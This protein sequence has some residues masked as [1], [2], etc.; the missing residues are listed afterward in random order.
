[1]HAHSIDQWVHQHAFLG[2]QHAGNE[3]RTW[4]VITLCGAMMAAEIAGT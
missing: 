1:M 2:D 4:A 3:R